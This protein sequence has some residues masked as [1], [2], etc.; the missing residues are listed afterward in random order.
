MLS[1]SPITVLPPIAV[2]PLFDDITPLTETPDPYF[3]FAAA[4]C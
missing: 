4:I 1:V 3:A 2:E